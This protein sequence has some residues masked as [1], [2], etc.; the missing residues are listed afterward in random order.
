MSTAQIKAAFVSTIGAA[1]SC[2]LCTM[3]YLDDGKAQ[4]LRFY[5]CRPGGSE[6]VVEATVPRGES[7][8][9]AARLAGLQFCAATPKHVKKPKKKESKDASAD[10]AEA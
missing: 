7:L 9:A 3:Q 2:T 1:G 8:I 10:S 6:E 5:V 4:L